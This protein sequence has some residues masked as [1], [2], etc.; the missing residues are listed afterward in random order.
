MFINEISASLYAW[1]LAD[2]GIERILDNL[3]EMTCCNSVYLIGLMHHEKR[4][5]TDFFYPHNPVRKTYFPEDSRAYWHPDLEYYKDSSIKPRTSERDLLKDTDWMSVLIKAARKRG[6]K[7][8][9][10][11]SHTFLD[12]ERA[13]G[14]LADCIQQDIYGT[15]FGQFICVN[16]PEARRYATSLFVELVSRYDLDY[17]QTC[18]VPYLAGRSPRGASSAAGKVMGVALGACFC[19]HCAK[20]AGEA[21]LDFEKIK[22]DLLTLADSIKNPTLA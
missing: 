2:E 3:Q 12:R 18:L 17:I 4:P 11:L 20:A 6:M 16:N 19:P 15:R 14:E 22:S 13:E 10:E 1:D 9:V 7:T 8:G 21:G 5:L